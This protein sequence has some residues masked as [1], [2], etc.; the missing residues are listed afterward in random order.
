[1]PMAAA[2]NNGQQQNDSGGRGAGKTRQRQS[3]EVAV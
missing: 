1:M 3:T 2:A